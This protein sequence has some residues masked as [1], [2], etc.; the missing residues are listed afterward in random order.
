MV[1][2]IIGMDLNCITT[3]QVLV[4]HEQFGNH[5]ILCTVVI[6][7]TEPYI[8]KTMGIITNTTGII[9]NG[10]GNENKISL[11][12]GNNS[13]PVFSLQKLSVSASIL[14]FMKFM[15]TLKKLAT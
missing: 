7:I 1:T 5:D 9:R 12:T 11:K 2:M 3:T 8:P 6:I 14:L 10:F 13:L 15:N 4:G